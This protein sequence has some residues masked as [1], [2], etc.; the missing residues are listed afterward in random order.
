MTCFM[1]GVWHYSEYPLDSEYARALNMLG[2]H[3][4]LNKIFH[5][6]YLTELWICLKFWICQCYTGLCR[7]QPIINFK[8]VLGIPRVLNMLR[9]EYARVANMPRLHRVLCKLYF[10]DSCYLNVSSSEYAKVLNVSRI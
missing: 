3:R 5:H 1:L 2:L 9:L 8:R 7:K 4:I 6:R 10:K